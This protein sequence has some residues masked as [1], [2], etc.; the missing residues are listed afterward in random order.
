M[1]SGELLGILSSSESQNVFHYTGAIQCFLSSNMYR[2]FLKEDPS[3]SVFIQ[4][5]RDLRI[6]LNYQSWKWK[7]KKKNTSDSIS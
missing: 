2:V 4:L 3:I 1:L 6:A 5:I 7:K